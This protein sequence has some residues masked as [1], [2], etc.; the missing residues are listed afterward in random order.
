MEQQNYFSELKD[1]AKGYVKD[2]ILLVKLQSAEKLSKIA[3]GVVVGVLLAFLG[4]FFL[5]FIS[6]AA[7]FY[8]A[9]LTE[10]FALGFAIVAGIYLVLMLLILLIKKSVIGKAITKATLKGFFAKKENSNG[11][12]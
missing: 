5:I 6:I 1:A 2:R 12:N 4:M 11:N 8:F 3:T 10:S 9:S 7:G